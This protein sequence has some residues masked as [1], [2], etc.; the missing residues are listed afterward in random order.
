MTCKNVPFFLAM[1]FALAGCAPSTTV[2]SLPTS[3]KTDPAEVKLAEAAA[4]VSQSLNSLAENQQATTPIPAGFKAP[5]PSDY[6][7]S[8]LVSISWSGPIEPLIQQIA[9]AAGYNVK[10]LGKE[11]AIPILVDVAADNEPLGR[12]LQNAGYQAGT[13]ADIVVFPRTKII[14]LRYKQV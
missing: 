1:I 2:S 5:D 9:K 6:G 13:G 4:S 14:E 3:P 10:V 8:N 7:M 12:V 11:P